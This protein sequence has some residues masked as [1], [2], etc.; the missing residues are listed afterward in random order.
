MSAKIIAF[1][2][3][4]GGVGKTANAVNIAACLALQRKRRVLVVDLDPQCNST[5]WLLSP[6]R[7]RKFTDLTRKTA[8]IQTTTH[9][10]YEDCIKG[11]SLFKIEQAIIRGVPH[12]GNGT[13]LLPKLDLLPGATDLYDIEFTAPHNALNRF[14]PCLI[15]A[16]KP[17][18]NDYDYIF[19]DCPPN[20]YHVAQTAVLA[21]HHIVVPYNPDFLAL[22]GLHVLCRQLR[23]L[24]ESFQAWRPGMTRNQVCAITVNRIDGRVGCMKTAVAEL[25]QLLD[26]LKDL[27]LVHPKCELLDPPVRQDAGISGSTSEHLPVILHTPQSIGSD[28]YTELTRAFVRHFE[29][30]LL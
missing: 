18:I 14:R 9:Q 11:T 29:E 15:K 7:Y 22:S 23:K 10:I 20:L 19:L 2:N 16:L 30:V 21:A 12:D 1:L 25:R 4:K 24:D 28:D 17:V 8:D 26:G 3:F 13:E 27:K 6:D 5:C